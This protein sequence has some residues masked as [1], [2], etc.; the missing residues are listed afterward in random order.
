MLT[1][2]IEITVETHEVLRI[3]NCPASVAWCPQCGGEA[4]MVAP[5]EA[6]K[7]CG[8]ETRQVYRWVEAEQIH[9]VESPAGGILVCLHSL[10][11]IEVAMNQVL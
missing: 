9:F 5:D 11:G 6:A 2:R 4:R 3:R 1:R 8:I 10:V 7:I